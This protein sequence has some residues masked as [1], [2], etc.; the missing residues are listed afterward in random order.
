MF[1]ISHLKL[2]LIKNKTSKIYQSLDKDNPIT[3]DIFPHYYAS[4]SSVT[5]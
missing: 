1:I 4:W 2:P 5:E 3:T